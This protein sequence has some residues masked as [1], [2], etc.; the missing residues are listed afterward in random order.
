MD[1]HKQHFRKTEQEKKRE[2]YTQMRAAI[3]TMM[4][5]FVL[6]DSP[7]ARAYVKTWYYVRRQM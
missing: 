2:Q 6:G 5:D 4:H 7:L 1:H 3:L